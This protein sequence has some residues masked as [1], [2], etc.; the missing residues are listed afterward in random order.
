MFQMKLNENLVLA[1]KEATKD[2]NENL[3]QKDFT[4]DGKTFTVALESNH[5]KLDINTTL[6][7]FSHEDEEYIIFR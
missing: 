3:Y 2:L 4:F 5:K 6:G 1:A 7:K